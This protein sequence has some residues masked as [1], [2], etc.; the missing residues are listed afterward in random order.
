MRVLPSPTF[1]ADTMGIIF[2]W[3][4]AQFPRL[5]SAAKVELDFSF[6]GAFQNAPQKDDVDYSLLF[7]YFSFV[8]WHEHFHFINSAT[9]AL[10]PT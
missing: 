10:L 2:C 9:S 7:L 6:Y 1:V 4:V 8:P 5:V 3:G